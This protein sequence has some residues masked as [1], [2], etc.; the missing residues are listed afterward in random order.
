M[1]PARRA[2][3]AEGNQRRRQI[4]CEDHGDN[5]H[6]DLHY[7]AFCV[8]FD[9]Y[10][11][12]VVGDGRDRIGGSPRN[13][14][15]SRVIT[16]S[17][18][19]RLSLSVSWYPSR[20]R[21]ERTTGYSSSGGITRRARPAKIGKT[22]Y[23]TAYRGVAHVVLASGLTIAG[24]TYCLSFARLPVFQTL[25]AP[26]AVGMLVAVAVAL[27]LVPAVLTVGSR[28]GLLDP[29]RRSSVRGW[30]RVGTAVVRW[31]APIF[32]ATCAVTLVRLAGA[33]RVQGEL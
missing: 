24:A 6:G 23:F 7:V 25:G 33:F 3:A 32:V 2:F 1:S 26:C 21:P 29:K 4:D 5:R 31:P 28:F 12:S 8:P 18:G 9:H 14:R 22:A 13:R 16:T 11:N 30:R 20:S 19:F 17:S 10:R 27:T 15:I